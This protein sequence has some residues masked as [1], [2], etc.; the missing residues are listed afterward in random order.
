MGYLTPDDAPVSTRGIVVFVPDHDA[1]LPVLLG[2][3]EVLAV[4]GNWEKHGL[5]TPEEIAERWRDCNDDT[6]TENYD[7]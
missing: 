6:A 5:A 7:T 1:A 3:L 4:P 2:L